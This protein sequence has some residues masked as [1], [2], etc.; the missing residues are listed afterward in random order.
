MMKFFEL[1]VQPVVFRWKMCLFNHFFYLMDIL[2]SAL[3]PLKSSYHSSMCVLF[4]S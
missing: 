3:K 4:K 2:F 1:K